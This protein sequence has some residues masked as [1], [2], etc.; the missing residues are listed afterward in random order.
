MVKHLLKIF[1]MALVMVFTT[2]L[3]AQVTSSGLS[4]RVI[5]EATK[6]ALIGASVRVKHLPTG[7]TYG[8]A[9]NDKG[10]Y[11]IQGMR[12]GGPYRVEVSYVGY[13]TKVFDDLRL[14]LGETE[15]LNVWLKDDA[16][17]LEQFVVTAERGSRF[18]SQKTGAG[19]NFTRKA[20]DRTPSISR[21]VFDIAKLNPQANAAGT[22]TS[23]AGSS[24]R[25]NSF[26]I[27][28]TVNNDVFG[29]SSSGVNGGQAGAT[30]VSLEAIEALQVVVAPY[31]V[32][33]SGF[34]G[35]GIN[36]ITKS[37]T[38]EF[39][40][41][42]Y[43]FYNDQNFYGKTPG[44]DL[45][46]RQKLDKQHDYSYG[47]TLGGPIVKDKLFFF[48]NGEIGDQD[49]PSSYALG[50][51]NQQIT[52]EEATRV[53]NV[54]KRLSG[55]KY[56]D[57]GLAAIHVPTKSYK[58]L[59][60]LDWNIA[61]GHR[62]SLRYNFV[63]GRR[64]IYGI[65]PTQFRFPGSG[66]YMNNL[67]HS[68]V[69]ELNSRF[70]DVV[71]N[72]FRFGYTRVRDFRE[73]A[74]GAF[75]TVIVRLSSN[76][77]IITGAEQYSA[78]NELDQDIFTLT[79][80]LTLSLGRH[81]LTFGTSNELFK[82]RNLFI[83]DNMGQYTYSSLE[84]FEKVGTPDEVLPEEYNYSYVNKQ[85]IKNNPR[86]APK[87]SAAQLGF[88]VQ[89]DWQVNDRLK[90]TYGLRADIPIFFDKPGFNEAFS[91]EAIAQTYGVATNQMPKTTVLWS[92][93]VGFRYTL[94][95]TNRAL[96]RGGV[97]IFTGRIPFVWISNNFSNTGLEYIRS[98]FGGKDAPFPQ[99][100]KFV[101]D[102][103]GQR[104]AKALS[105]EVDVVARNFKYPQVLRANLA[106]DA[107]LPGDVK[108]TIEAMFTKNLN[109]ILYHN[110]WIKETATPLQFGS[111][112]RVGFERVRK[113]GYTSVILLDNTSK[114]Y[115]YNMTAQLSK[116][117]DFGLSLSAAYT[118]GRSYGL[119]DGG[120]SQAYSGW[121]YAIQ[122]N[123]TRHLRLTP[124]SQD[125]L[126]RVIATASYRVEYAKHF[127]TTLSLVYNGQSGLPYSYIYGSDMNGDGAR[128][129]DILYVPT[130]DELYNMS[131][132]KPQSAD[133]YNKFIENSEL[134]AYRGQSLSRNAFR[135]PFV[136]MIDLHFAQD[137]FF[138]VG[139]KRHTLQLN[140]DVQ[141]LANLLNAN[142]GQRYSV[143]N[144]TYSPVKESRGKYSFSAPRGVNG[145][146]WTISDLASRWKAQIGVKY[147]F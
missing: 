131:W 34:T 115:T 31:D 67:T 15:Q 62:L 42:A 78:A 60:R 19:S 40:G 107:V 117:F 13:E 36:A 84:D 81:N 27:D 46:D 116:D 93:R 106:F 28:G 55:G 79:D 38:N 6:E 51:G 136:H 126:H 112:E 53:Q 134:A 41:S 118:F 137:F 123:G 119:M 2:S 47:V 94:D 103:D 80:N 70:S 88:Y 57:G 102:G 16:Q 143:G 71:N 109:D 26:Q 120:S 82:I 85:V 17:T 5:D 77:R 48:L 45:K 39:H 98:Q 110:L 68:G 65:S 30:P 9:T 114:G 63:K 56:D 54:V 61:S 1:M 130:Q 64:L 73:L 29:L 133:G 66:Y 135:L 146:V 127:A 142:W 87:F 69:L 139:G 147:I 111:T 58:A 129:N 125:M 49:Q 50:S 101:A 24:N 122:E 86:W 104:Q 145:N 10:L 33:Q 20:I 76:N 21:S 75:P 4:G 91:K 22:G 96:I 43:G 8:A 132:D 90:L 25:Y 97:G 113:D 23:F 83:R 121:Q 141:N 12:P 52:L 89:D 138:N 7:T 92:P 44:T 95:E 14:S 11:R 72:E 124:S 99:D 100:F 37:G 108:M 144:G 128:L 18:N 105:T 140:A 3:S 74:G 32:R 59:G 35:G